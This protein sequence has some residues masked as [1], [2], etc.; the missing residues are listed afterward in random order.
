GNS[1]S[2][3]GAG[4]TITQFRAIDLAANTSA[5]FPTVA[6]ATNT[7]K[8]DKPLPTAPTVTGGGNATAWQNVASVTLDAA[9][10]TDAGG[11]G[12][13]ND[14]VRGSRNGRPTSR[15]ACAAR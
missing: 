2:V 6:D 8:I 14:Q 9:G 1:A 15:P 5:W 7:V 10:S 13:A 12:F 3:S 4:T 11:S